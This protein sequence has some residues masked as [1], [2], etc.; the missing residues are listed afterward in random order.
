LDRLLTVE[1]VADRLGTSARIAT[2]DLDA[3][4]RAGRVEVGAIPLLA[5]RRGA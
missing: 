3:Y 2:A 5:R 4:V 1:E